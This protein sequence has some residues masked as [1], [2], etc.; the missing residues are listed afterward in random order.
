MNLT[1]LIGDPIDPDDISVD[2]DPSWLTIDWTQV[3]KHVARMRSSIFVNSKNGKADTVRSLQKLMLKSRYNWLYAIRKVTSNKGADSPGVD[4]V[5]SL[6]NSQKWQL[7]IDLQTSSLSESMP[8]PV[9]RIYIPKP[10]GR[11]RPLGVP[12]ITD[13]VYQAIVLNTL[14]PEWE[15]KFENGSYG[16][17][18]GRSVSDAVRAIFVPLSLH[19][20]GAAQW[21][22]DCDIKGCFDNVN[23]DFLIACLDNFPAAASIRRWLEAGIFDAQVFTE[24]DVGFPQGGIISAFL[25]NIALHGLQSALGIKLRPNGLVRS[26]A[27]S[28]R[29]YCRYADDFVVLTKTR[30]DA[31]ACVRIISDFMAIRGLTLKKSHIYHVTPPFV[32]VGYE[33]RLAPKAGFK[34]DR[35]FRVVST[36]PYVAEFVD[37]RCLLSPLLN[38]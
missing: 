24:S 20:K 22:V 21:V 19:S 25:M 2:L 36:D 23:H 31:L 35:V 17:R 16:F 33:F 1:P 37:R 12:T 3:N 27:G 34:A 15:A 6:T 13:R 38:Q 9:R 8:P 14:E 32:F 10:D 18:P 30:D 4:G 28:G 7:F 29:H 5:A 11:W 26:D